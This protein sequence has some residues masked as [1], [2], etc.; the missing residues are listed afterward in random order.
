ML[1]R[2]EMTG[3]SQLMIERVK[4]E[5]VSKY[6]IV[7]CGGDN[8]AEG[9]F[10]RVQGMVEKPSLNDAPSDMAVVGRYILSKA[11]WPLLQKTPIGAGGEIQLTDAIAMLLKQAPVEAYCLT[12][13]SHDCGDKIG[14]MKAF[15]EYGLRHK[16]TGAVFRQWL[17]NDLQLSKQIAE[18]VM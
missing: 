2:Y 12:G 13:K 5:D 14:Y 15:V 18:E 8:V 11:I 6:G 7:D 1:R 17:K 3:A 10:G 16:A 4:H 9:H